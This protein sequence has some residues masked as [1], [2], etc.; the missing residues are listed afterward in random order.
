[1]AALGAPFVVADIWPTSL[2]PRPFDLVC[3]TDLYSYWCTHTSG[4]SD[5]EAEA[6]ADRPRSLTT[7]GP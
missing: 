2:E 1:M 7:F 6:I 3:C 4:S 5:H